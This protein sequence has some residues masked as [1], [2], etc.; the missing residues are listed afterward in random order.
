[1]S[2]LPALSR[3]SLAPAAEARRRKKRKKPPQPPLAVVTIA[4]QDVTVHQTMTAFVWGYDG[5]VRHV[6]GTTIDLTDTIA[7]MPLGTTQDETLAALRAGARSLARTFL[8]DQG[9]D[10]PEDR[11]AAVML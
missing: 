5:L 2:H 6:T 3:R 4:I 11:I 10:V 8:L 9:E 7:I 1:M